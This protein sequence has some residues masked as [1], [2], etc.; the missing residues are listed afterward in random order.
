M[1]MDDFFFK[2]IINKTIIFNNELNP[3]FFDKK[4][5]AGFLT[6]FKKNLSLNKDMVINNIS[7]YKEYKQKIIF[8]KQ[9]DEILILSLMAKFINHNVSLSSLHYCKKQFFENILD[10][11]FQFKNCYK[12][13]TKLL[14]DCLPL[15][16]DFCL[17]LDEKVFLEYCQTKVTF[18]TIE[19]EDNYFKQTDKILPFEQNNNLFTFFE[20]LNK[21]NN[22]QE[23]QQSFI[24]NIK[25]FLN[26]LDQRLLNDFFRYFLLSNYRNPYKDDFDAQKKIFITTDDCVEFAVKSLKTTLPKKINPLYKEFYTNLEEQL[27]AFMLMDKNNI[28]HNK[29]SKE[30][31]II[32]QFQ[33]FPFIKLLIMKIWFLG[34][35]T[36]EKTLKIIFKSV[37]MKVLMGEKLKETM[38][39]DLCN[40]FE[41]EELLYKENKQLFLN[42]IEATFLSEKDKLHFLE[43]YN[44]KFAFDDKEMY[45]ML[46]LIGSFLD[47]DKE[48]HL[49]YKKYLGKDATFVLNKIVEKSKDESFSVIKKALGNY[50]LSLENNERTDNIIQKKDK[51]LLSKEKLSLL[52]LEK[53]VIFTTNVQDGF[54]VEDIVIRTEELKKFFIKN[55]LEF[56]V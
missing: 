25:E 52:L 29:Y 9:A 44:E 7:F 3:N 23:K 10:S 2:K 5:I 26:P 42:F 14:V 22:Q 36:V 54:N 53:N 40:S 19:Q 56:Y 13:D 11:T 27:Y 30:L 35:D 50:F 16:K 31:H 8:T 49:T 18:F 32:Q 4:N 41:L 55:I 20:E 12:E 43:R 17:D 28:N 37:L 46:S 45:L 21:I 39:V 6:F 34:G 24:K 1:S 15:I 47:N 33:N 48:K 38:I 51:M